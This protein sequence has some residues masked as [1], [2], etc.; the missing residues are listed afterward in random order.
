MQIAICDDEQSSRTEIRSYL[1]EYKTQRTIQMDI[2]EFKSGKDFLN[3]DLIFDIVFMDFQM[4][5]L[6]GLETAKL[7]RQKN[8]LCSIVFVTSYDYF[9][10]D[11]FEVNTYR[12]FDKPVSP[13]KIY[14]MLDS[15]IAQQKKF[16]PIMIYDF[17]GRRTIPYKDIIY[18][19]GNG[20]YSKLHTVSGIIPCSKTVIAALRL[21]PQYC[22]LRVHKSFAVNMYYVSRIEADYVLMKNGHKLKL[23]KVFARNFKITYKEFIKNYYVRL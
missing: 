23:G 22:F 4:P 18:I 20:K 2:Y 1:I 9:V 8:S 11:A 13:D 16:A 7:L 6:D 3:C 5:D 17:D 10:K 12:F 19:E 15:F 14:S 21:L